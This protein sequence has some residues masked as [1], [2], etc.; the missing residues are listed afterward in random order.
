M[1]GGENQAIG[2]HSMGTR[3]RVSRMGKK[4]WGNKETARGK[5]EDG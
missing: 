2:T 5:K 4:I 3:E 1:E